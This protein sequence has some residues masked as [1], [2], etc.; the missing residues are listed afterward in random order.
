VTPEQTHHR[1]SGA[2]AA[3]SIYRSAAGSAEYECACARKGVG[4]QWS[5][6]RNL[7]MAWVLTLPAAIMLS[8]GVYVLFRNVFG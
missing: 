4:L 5:T 1:P 2:T 6:V 8:D 7:L 3:F